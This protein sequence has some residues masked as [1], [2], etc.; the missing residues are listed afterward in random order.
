[1]MAERAAG[2]AVEHGIRGCDAVYVA[3]AEQF[4][5][6]LV[7]LDRQQLERGAAVAPVREP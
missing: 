6:V 7:T 1:M 5:D 3:L 2:I 4:G